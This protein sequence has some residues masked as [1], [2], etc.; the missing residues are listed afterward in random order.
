MSEG[1]SIVVTALVAEFRRVRNKVSG[2][3][4]RLAYAQQQV[5]VESALLAEYQRDMDMLADAL[6]SNGGGIPPS[7]EPLQ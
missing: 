7:D 1:P 2:A 3:A 4:G 5:Q 6:L